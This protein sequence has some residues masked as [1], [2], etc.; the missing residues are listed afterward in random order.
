MEEEDRRA[1]AGDAGADDGCRRRRRCARRRSPRTSPGLPDRVGRLAARLVGPGHVGQASRR[2]TRRRARSRRRRRGP[3]AA[4][5][6]RPRRARRRARGARAPGRGRSDR[7]RSRAPRST[8]STASTACTRSNGRPWRSAA[9]RVLPAEAVEEQR[10]AAP[11]PRPGDLGR[12]AP[13][14]SCSSAEITAR[15]SA[16]L[17]AQAQRPLGAVLEAGVLG[18]SLG[19][20]ACSCIRSIRAPQAES[21]S[22]T[23]S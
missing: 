16:R 23:R 4:S 13:T 11:P 14:A 20:A 7:R 10:E 19:H 17:R 21:F 18:A 8:P 12:S 2:G 5:R 9:G 6:R 22:S 3:A 15:S 1:G